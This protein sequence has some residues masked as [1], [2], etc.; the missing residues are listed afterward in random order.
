ME[1]RSVFK[2]KIMNNLTFQKNQLVISL[3][4]SSKKVDANTLHKF[5]PS[6]KGNFIAAH[7]VAIAIFVHVPRK[8]PK[9]HKNL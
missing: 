1:I 2:K 7:F 3:R 5:N 8:N 4:A 9:T 6:A